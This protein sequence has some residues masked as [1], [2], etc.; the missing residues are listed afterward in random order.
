ML[1]FLSG[2]SVIKVDDDYNKILEIILSN[3][4]NVYNEIRVGYKY[5]L[6]RSVSVVSSIF[7]NEKLYSNGNNYFLYVDTINYFYKSKLEYEENKDIYYSKSL[8]FDGLQGYLEITKINNRYFIELMFNYSKME[9][10]VDESQITETITNMSYILSSISYNDIAIKTNVIDSI[11]S[12]VKEN[13]FNIFAPKNQD[14]DIL[15]Y[16]EK[17]DAFDGTNFNVPDEDAI[18]SE[19]IVEED[20]NVNGVR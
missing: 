12:D 2:C 10:Y 7:G 8:D 16:I 4:K 9:S 18:R 11:N 17:Y 15:E 19:D 5:Y 1:V 14:V 13:K 20:V 3:E 6:P